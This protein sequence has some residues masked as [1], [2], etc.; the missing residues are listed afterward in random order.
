MI[1]NF[2]LSLFLIVIIF[3]SIGKIMPVQASV[4]NLS[5][6]ILLDVE[7]NGEAWYIYPK[8]N[9]RYYLGRPSD[10]F[11][12]MRELGLGILE[13]DFQKIASAEMAVDGDLELAKKLSGRIV[14]QVERNGEAWY[15]NPL[16]LKKHYLGRPDDAFKIM[17]ELGLGINKK[18][19]ATI[20]KNT[21]N[22]S[23][24][25]YSSY[26]YRSLVLVDGKNFSLDVIEIN[27][28]NPNLKIITD[29]ANSEDCLGPCPA[30]PLIDYVVENDAFAGINGTY[31]NP[32]ASKLNYYFFPVYNSRLKKFINTDQLKY[33]TT[34]PIMAFDENNKFYYFKDSRDFVGLDQFESKYGVKLQSAIG[35]KPRLV[36]EGK[37]LLI[38]WELDN[39]QTNTKALRTAIAY[40]AG[41]GKGK[42]YLVVARSATVVDLAEILK[43]MEVDYAI[44]LDGG[45]STALYYND[46]YMIGPGRNVPNAILFAQ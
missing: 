32:S 20:H 15:I 45:N 4:G 40:K 43:V 39:G 22:E 31:F 38:D 2:S 26:R 12:V 9:K 23:I 5:G 25:M 33:P 27:L 29:T 37:S 6:R 46:E 3:L 16:T 1:K 10:A 41:S 44:N 8:D 24:N 21:L 18:N 14:L 30:K 34:G 42:I 19:L 28:N 17:R 11:A 13:L 7:R 35:N 36:E